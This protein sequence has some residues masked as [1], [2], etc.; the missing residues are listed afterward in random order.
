M[1]NT[2]EDQLQQE[3]RTLFDLDTQKYLQLYISTAQN[4]SEDSWKHDIQEIYRCV[5][6]IKGGAVTVGAEAILE[7]STVLEDLLSDLRY[8]DDAPSLSDR[9][10]QEILV[11]AGELLTASLELSSNDSATALADRILAMRSLLQATY[12]PNWSDQ[13][14]LHQE[15][16]EQGF[17]LVVLELDMAIEQLSPNSIVTSDVVT[18]AADT[19]M[20]LQQIGEEINLGE[21]WQTLLSQSQALIQ[22][23]SSDVW[24]SQWSGYLRSLK[25][26]AKHG[27]K[28]PELSMPIHQLD[29]TDQSNSS[30]QTNQFEDFITEITDQISDIAEFSEPVEPSDP[31]DPLEQELRNLFDLDTQ[32]SLQLYMGTVKQLQESTWQQDI[33]QMYRAIHTI[34]GGAVTVGAEAILQVSTVFEDLLSDLRNVDPVPDLSNGFLQQVL[35]ECGELLVASLGKSAVP[36][37]SI[38]RILELQTQVKTNY[39]EEWNE[40][41][42]LAR[43]FAEQGFDLVIL[44]LEMAIEQLPETGT[45]SSESLEVA[46]MTLMQLQEIGNEIGLATDWQD[47][48]AQTQTLLESPDCELWRS[49]FMNRLRTLKEY[50]RNGG[51]APQI[52]KPVI[53]KPL[54]NEL[55]FT[56]LTDNLADATNEIAEIEDLPS[57]LDIVPEQFIQ[58]IQPKR[59]KPKEL[60]VSAADVQIPVP[61]ERLDRSSQH[62]VETLMATRAT[63]GFYQLVYDNLL[64][65]V[66][67][68]Q[69]SIQYIGQLRE[70]QDDYA[71]IESSKNQESPEVESYRQG[72]T[73]IN[74][75]LEISLRLTEL[76]A[77]TGESARRTAE[78]LQRLERSLRGLQQTLE[79]SR[80]V[81]FETLSFRVRGILRDLTTRNLDKRAQLTVI[82]EKLELDA[83]TLRNLE[84][85]L[86]HLIRNSFDHGLETVG[87]RAVLGKPQKGTITLSLVRRGSVFVLKVNDDGRGIDPEKIQKIAIAKNLPLTNTDN[88]AALLAVICQPGFTSAQVVSDISGRGVGMDVVA[89]QIEAIGGQLSLDTKLGVGTTFTIQIPVPN[90]FVRCMLLQAGDRIFGVPTSDIFTTMLLGDLL[91]QKQDSALYSM[92]ITEDT[93]AV[94]ALDLY[95][96]WQGETSNRTYLPTSIAVRT[97]RS[98]DTLGVWI[99]AD[100]LVGQSDLLVNAIPSPL[101]SPV[102]V[103]GVSLQS[104]GKLIPIIDPVSLIDRLLSSTQGAIAIP[105]VTEVEDIARILVVDDAALMR[106]RIESSLSNQGYNIH[107]CSDGLEAWDWMQNHA[108]PTMLIT[109]I[110]MPGMD[111]FTLID[112]CRQAGMNMPI[113]V[114]SSRLAEEW[115][116]E[117]KRLGADDYLTKGFTTPELLAKVASLLAEN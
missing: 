10:L 18:I 101:T 7:V 37:S 115:S 29:Q 63:Q 55:E 27:G 30:N 60:V 71:L 98:Q 67:L 93:G 21:S 106:R 72:Y 32:N 16:A 28:I 62:L 34:K 23:P 84:P 44:D 69:D 82:G 108:Q 54:T 48:L 81:A 1:L 52:A 59:K 22:N 24:L 5:H 117:T 97:K 112:R 19:M 107:I 40:Q 41:K 20:Q 85:V 65:I 66:S 31:V 4:L 77:E 83:G 70:V 68:A 89:N 86:L 116:K 104:D 43:E 96:Y 95:Q 13:D 61:L 58:Y 11:E 75:L 88:S 14:Q 113:M 51:K 110:E 15:F 26:C 3:L 36:T 64:P 87:E 90:L 35:I 33:Q 45:V 100:S 17:D 105:T 111:G 53:T 57:S 76:G 47:L 79:E 99:I 103:M 42:Q 92:T 102:G 50:A 8:L 12:L 46:T 39:L 94:P 25:E 49:Q 73:A 56:N 78:S 2:A 114:I 6:T 80:L 9:Q 38:Q 91:W 109:D 74:R